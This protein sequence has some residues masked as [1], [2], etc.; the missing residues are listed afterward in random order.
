MCKR[1]DSTSCTG[2][3]KVTLPRRVWDG[4]VFGQYS[5]PHPACI[6]GRWGLMSVGPSLTNE[7]GNW[8]INA[9]L[10]SF[11]GT[12]LRC[13][14][15]ALQRG[16]SRIEPHLP[17]VERAQRGPLNCLVLFPHLYLPLPLCY[18]LQPSPSSGL[19]P[20]SPGQLNQNT[21][22]PHLEKNP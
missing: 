2:S 19:R 4:G 10:L 16:P 17:T 8:W 3:G 22:F 5:L 14:R 9:G 21:Q 11:E 15:Q 1:M 18:F 12:I 7:G 6:G 20:C 13:I